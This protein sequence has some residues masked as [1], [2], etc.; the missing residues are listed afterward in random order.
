MDVGFIGLGAMGKAMASR[1]INAGHRVRVWN[2]SPGPAREL[3]TCGA[4]TA[5]TPR[6]AVYG[7]VC[8]SMLADDGAVRDVI[9]DGNIFPKHGTSTIHVNMST[10][11]VAFAKELTA[12]HAALV[13]PYLAAPVFGLVD[14]AASGKLNIVAAG[15]AAVIDRVQP[16]FDAM[17]QKTW[18]VGT[19]PSQANAVKVAG[20]LMIACA[21]ETMAEASALTQAH[22][23]AAADFLAVMAH[24]PF[25]APIYRHYG[26]LIAERRYEPVNFKLSLG[27]KD[28]RLALSA[29]EAVKVPLPFAN[30]LHDSFIDAIAHG[31]G[32]KDWAAIADVAKRRTTIS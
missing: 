32:H 30:I 19:D 20:N 13:V 23:V 5:A 26:G 16:L 25:D 3:E 4:E 6:D 18:R 1:L 28:V 21:I 27:L 9:I 11:S 29:G 8:I 24:G 17:G 15:D 22:G 2:R 7:N 31:D 10:I 12:Y 14:M